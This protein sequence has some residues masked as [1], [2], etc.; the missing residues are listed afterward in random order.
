MPSAG[1]VLSLSDFP[2]GQRATKDH[3]RRFNI[4]ITLGRSLAYTFSAVVVVTNQVTTTFSSAPGL[5]GGS[6]HSIASHTNSSSREG[7]SA[8]E[9][10]VLGGRGGSHIIPALGN[11]WHHC[12]SNRLILEQHENRR[13]MHL[14]KSPLA[15]AVSCRFVVQE[16]GLAEVD[17]AV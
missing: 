5:H 1:C 17:A 13:E 2:H 6:R 12:V 9:T 11:T 15:P 3:S 16:S 7:N 4:I 8:F 10:E 14:T